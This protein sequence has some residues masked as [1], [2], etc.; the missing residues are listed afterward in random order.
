MRISEAHVGRTY[1]P[2]EPYLVSREKIAEFAAAIGG[3]DAAYTGPDAVAP[4]TFAAVLAARAWQSMFADPELDVALHRTIHGD[5][6][7]TWTRP[8]RA[9]DEVVATLGIQSVR[10]RGRS[11]IIGV[12][13]E[14]AVDGEVVCTS[15]ST[16][17]QT[18][19]EEASA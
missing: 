14:L 3:D 11:A 15:T 6:R 18:W 5:Q 10:M 19:P 17:F 8:L 4:P 12:G 7:F 13:V 1:P 2:S 16:L 9:G